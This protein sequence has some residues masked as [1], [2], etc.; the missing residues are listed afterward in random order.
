MLEPRIQIYPNDD[1]PDAP[2]DW[3]ATGFSITDVAGYKVVN[4]DGLV[5]G[6][7]SFHF[8]MPEL[9][10]GAVL[11]ANAGDHAD[12][13]NPVAVELLKDVLNI[14]GIEIDQG[15]KWK[16][17]AETAAKVKKDDLQRR[18]CP[19]SNNFHDQGIVLSAYTG[20]YCNK[21]YHCIVIETGSDPEIETSTE[22]HLYVNATDRSNAFT[23]TFQYASSER[24]F[25]ARVVD[26]FD[27]ESLFVPA[28]FQLEHGRA[29]KVGAPLDGE[30]D[31][32]IWFDLVSEDI[33]TG[34]SEL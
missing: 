25:L 17:D 30:L 21:G 23:A 19:N 31:E 27:G 11:F 29:V 18:L 13:L 22:Q 24:I 34:Q 8:F 4:H 1:E 32:Y 7:Q 10:F 26:Y 2:E 33:V 5:S 12:I 3:Y 15:S 28:E 9:K 14:T 20:R 6:F 16:K